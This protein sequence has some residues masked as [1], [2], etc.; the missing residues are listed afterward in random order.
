MGNQNI[1]SRG[2]WVA[3]EL[4][5]LLGRLRAPRLLGA[6]GALGALGS[7]LGRLG[8]REALLNKFR[9]KQ[10]IEHVLIE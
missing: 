5:E 4:L 7:L 10:S 2:S 6:L 1:F 9:R 8:A 3:S